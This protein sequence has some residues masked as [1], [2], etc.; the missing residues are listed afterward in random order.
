MFRVYVSI[1]PKSSTVLL[2][3]L[4]GQLHGAYGAWLNGTRR[5]QWRKRRSD[6][7]LE[8]KNCSACAQGVG[9]PTTLVSVFPGG[10]Q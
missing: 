9:F 4:I 10:R 8:Q 1:A 3:A 7:L 5:P 2:V 6:C